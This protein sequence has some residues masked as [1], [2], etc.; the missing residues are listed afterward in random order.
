MKI[1]LTGSIGNIGKPLAQTLIQK[2][3]AVTVV[4]SKADRQAAIEAL[5]ATAAIGKMQDAT[6]LA[7][8][9]KG[10]D[11]V[12]CMET[13]EA[14]AFFDQSLNIFAL[15]NEIGTTYKQA[16]EQSGVKNVVHL[17]SIGGHT[18][19]GN[20]I[21]RFHYDVEH[22]LQQLPDDVSIKVMRPVGFY[23]NLLRSIPTIK[24]KGAFISNYGGDQKEPWVSPLDIAAAIVEEIEL[25]FN[26]RTIRYIASEEISPNE[27]AKV[28]GEAIGKP[29]LKWTV[30]SD[31]QLLNNWLSIGFNKEIAQGFAE[32]QA[33]QGTGILYEDYYRNRPILGK[34]KMSDFAKDFA[35]VYQQD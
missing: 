29:D 10:A 13:N 27:I 31:E 34:T 16:I 20:G 33:A 23:T 25:P 6:F 1:V 5:G 30:I 21:L 22:I 11:I 24:N 8:T 14:G 17:S 15:Y 3:H 19:T 9:F 26:G 35:H 7:A 28:L 2:G 4:S 18:N 32:M 12:Y